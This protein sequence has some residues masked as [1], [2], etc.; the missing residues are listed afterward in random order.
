MIEA[1]AAATTIETTT[2][3]TPSPNTAHLKQFNLFLDK[4]PLPLK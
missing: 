4:A 2:T 3:L 1:T